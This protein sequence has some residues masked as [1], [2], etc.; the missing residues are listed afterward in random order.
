MFRKPIVYFLI[1]LSLFLLVLEPLSYNIFRSPQ[2]DANIWIAL[3]CLCASQLFVWVALIKGFRL[4]RMKERGF[5]LNLI[6]I[7]GSSIIIL[8]FIYWS[9][10]LL[11][12]LHEFALDRQVK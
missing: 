1:G 8:L 7:I 12:L 6:T 10:S 4:V 9:S 11:Y 3:V 5:A 2:N